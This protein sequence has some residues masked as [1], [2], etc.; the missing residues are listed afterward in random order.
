MSQGYSSFSNRAFML[1]I[2][3]L[4]TVSA[5]AAIGDMAGLLN[6]QLNSVANLI[7][8]IGYVAG[9]GF[10]VA[11]VFK[12]KQ[13]RDSPTQV[14]I[15]TPFAMLAVAVALVY[16]PSLITEAGSSAFSDGAIGGA[17]GSGYQDLG[18]D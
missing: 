5:Y 10:G 4:S 13:H 6:D 14:P 17:Q 18:S 9:M 16:L 7:G 2:L 1:V 8:S 3:A 15:G 12:F 11:S